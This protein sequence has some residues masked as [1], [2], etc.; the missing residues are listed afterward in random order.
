[1]RGVDRF[2]IGDKVKVKSSGIKVEIRAFKYERA[3]ANGKFIESYRYFVRTPN[4]NFLWFD[5]KLLEPDIY[6]FDPKFEI[7]LLDALIDAHLKN[8]Q[9]DVV[10]KLNEEKNRLEV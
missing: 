4:G 2:E 8:G 7:K 3:Y 10:M 9:F 1:V 5:E 6:T